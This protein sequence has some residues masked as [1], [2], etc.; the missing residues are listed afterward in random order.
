MLKSVYCKYYQ[1]KDGQ[2]LTQIADY[3]CLS[4]RLLAK[5]NGLKTQVRAGQILV[6]PTER[7]NAYTV[8]EQDT[9]ALL[10]GGKESYEKKNGTDIFYLGMRV[11]L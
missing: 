2:T 11:L 4:P 3:F 8:R 9:K 6:I 5:E 10:C 1:V 7:G